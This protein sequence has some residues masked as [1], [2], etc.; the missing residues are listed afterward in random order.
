[1]GK[2][3]TY[4]RKGSTPPRAA[5]LPSPPEG[6]LYTE[7]DNLLYEPNTATN[8]GG[9]VEL[10]YSVLIAGPYTLKTTVAFASPT[11]LGPSVDLDSG[12]Y[13]ARTIGNNVNYFGPGPLS[14][15][16]FIP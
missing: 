11:D 7:E 5:L 4:R 12:Y 9:S 1:V 6:F 13:K 15:P 2:W 8:A 16:W 14:T 10:H 3:A